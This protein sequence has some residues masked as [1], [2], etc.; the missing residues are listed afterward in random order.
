MHNRIKL[1]VIDIVE[2]MNKWEEVTICT[3][4][5]GAILGSGLVEDVTHSLLNAE[6]TGIGQS[7]ETVLLYINP[8]A[9]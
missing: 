1:L 2:R 3:D 8:E 6:V 4:T 9:L 7:A 5:D